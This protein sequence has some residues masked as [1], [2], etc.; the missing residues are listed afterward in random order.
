MIVGY[1]ADITDRLR[2]GTMTKAENF[3]ASEKISRIFGRDGFQWG[4]WPQVERCS[5]PLG[6][7]NLLEAAY[8]CK[9]SFLCLSRKTLWDEPQRPPQAACGSLRV[10]ITV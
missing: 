8:Y 9:R 1:L 5:T 2:S 4:L 10:P 3:C 6:S 7:D